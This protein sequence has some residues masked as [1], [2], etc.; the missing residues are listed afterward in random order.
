MSLLPGTLFGRLALL[1]VGVVVVGQLAVFMV[2]RQDRASLLARQFGE[3]KIAQLQA[4]REAMADSNPGERGTAF[5]IGRAYGARVVPADRRPMIGMEPNLAEYDELERSLKSRLGE[6]TEVRVSPRM[7]LL[8]VRLEAGQSAYWA[9]FPLPRPPDERFPARLLGWTAMIALLLVAAAWFFARRIA[10]PLRELSAAVSAVRQGTF[11]P[12]LPEAGPREIAALAGGFNRMIGSLRQVEQDR[13]VLLAGVS[14]DLRTPLARM[15][16]GIE[17]LPGDDATK[18]GMIEDIEE[19]DRSLSQFLDFARG[20]EGALENASID[21]IVAQALEPYRRNGQPVALQPGSLPES[22]VRPAGIRRLVVNLVD[23]ALRYGAP[24]VVVSTRREGSV[25]VVEVADHGPGV[26]PEQVERL[27]RPFTRLE[28]AR[29][30]PAGTGLGLAIV[31]RIADIHGGRFELL[32]RPG[33]G[34]LAR[35]TLPL[36]GVRALARAPATVG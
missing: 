34:T 32:P 13:A 4:M 8:W 23:N 10:K 24:P 21:D 20:E 18:A 1:L 11:P 7:G 2:F 5:R 30:G 27:K 25:A 22:R 12:P 29:S 36:D 31:E 14:H 33:G 35:V 15:R 26:P 9:G 17:I 19:M 28:N 3:T 6:E 16:I